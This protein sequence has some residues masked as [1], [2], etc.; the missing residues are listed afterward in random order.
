MATNLAI[1][2][3]LIN[4]AVEVGHHTTK[5]AAVTLALQEYI[6]RHK[7]QQI[8]ELFGTIKYAPDYNYK[9]RRNRSK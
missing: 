6:Q 5:K 1:N 7:Q 8:T 2:D 9:K 3:N 4:E